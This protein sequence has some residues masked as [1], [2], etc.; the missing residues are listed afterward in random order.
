MVVAIVSSL[1]LPIDSSVLSVIRSTFV[2]ILLGSGVV[3]I[4]IL[5]AWSDF[6]GGDL[7]R[8]IPQEILDF[9][10]LSVTSMSSCSMINWCLSLPDIMW[11]LIRD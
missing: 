11:I 1:S 3:V 8:L 4:F 9:S 7:Q 2:L 5:F 6:H 10:F